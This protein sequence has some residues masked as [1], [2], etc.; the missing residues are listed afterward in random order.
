MKRLRAFILRSLAGG[1]RR[2]AY[3]A[4]RW[5]RRCGWWANFFARLAVELEHQA[6][7][8]EPPPKV[9]A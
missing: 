4:D 5:R 3:N 2:A 1:V 7:T 8:L 6:D 9:V